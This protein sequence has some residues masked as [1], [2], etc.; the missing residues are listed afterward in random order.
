MLLPSRILPNTLFN[1]CERAATE[2]AV[3]YLPKIWREG[4]GSYVPPTEFFTFRKSD[5]PSRQIDIRLPELEIYDLVR[6]LTFPPF[7]KPYF[8]V[9]GNKVELSINSN[10]V[11]YG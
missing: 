4:V 11:C 2:L 6:A 3:E 9:G 8:L 1:R 10:G 5:L 7:E